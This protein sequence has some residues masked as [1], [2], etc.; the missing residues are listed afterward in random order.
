[1]ENGFDPREFAK[2]NNLRA[3]GLYWYD[4]INQ[5][6]TYA[7]FDNECVTTNGKTIQEAL[8]NT[9][10]AVSERRGRTVA[11]RKYELLRQ[12]ENIEKALPE[13]DAPAL[14]QGAAE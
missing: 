7:H 3:I 13:L 10:K 4:E 11:N 5:F 14:S 12:R 1:M 9:V 8:D 6:S 2:A